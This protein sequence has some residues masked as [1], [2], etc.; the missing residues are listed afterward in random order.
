M[1][2]RRITF[3]CELLEDLHAGSGLGWLGQIDDCHARDAQ[4]RAVVWSSTLSGVLRDVADELLA[5]E[6]PLATSARVRRLFGSEGEDAR[7]SLITRSLHFEFPDQPGELVPFHV[8]TS[9]A[10]EVHSRRPLDHTLRTIEMASAGQTAQAELRFHGDDDDDRFL[11]L[12]LSRLTAI[13]GGK[14]RGQGQIRI[15]LI[16]GETGD[17]PAPPTPTLPTKGER[18]LRVLLR[19]LEPVCI[20]TTGFPGNVIATESFLPGTALRGAWLTAMNQCGATSVDEF[21]KSANVNFGNGTFVDTNFVGASLFSVISWPLPLTAQAAKATERSS[22]T[23]NGDWWKQPSWWAT[24]TE[25]HSA[26]LAN[27]SVE[28]DQLHPS[29]RQRA[30]QSNHEADVE[31]VKFKRVKSEDVLVSNDSGQTLFR[32]RPDCRVLLRNRSPVRRLGRATDSRRDQATKLDQEKG[33]LFA[34]TVLSEGQHFVA[35][36]TFGSTEL[37]TQFIEQVKSLLATPGLTGRASEASA[38]WLRVGRGGRPV[39]VERYEWLSEDQPTT[40]DGNATEFTLTLTSDLIGRRDD[41]TFLTTLDAAALESLTGA[42]GLIG[43]IEV[44]QRV[45]VSETRIVRGFNTAAGT[46]RSPALA[47]KRGS[48]F[49]VRSS[50]TGSDGIKLRDLFESLAKTYA[51]SGGLGE[52]TEEGFGRFFLNSPAHRSPT[53][54][55]TRTAPPEPSVTSAREMAIDAVLSA[56]REMNLDRAVGLKGFPAR[57]QWQWLRHEAEVPSKQPKAIVDEIVTAAKKL[58]GAN[59]K[60]EVPNPDP[61]LVEN[62]HKKKN[63]SL[64]QCLRFYIDKF[65]HPNGPDAKSQR[66]FLIYL[67]RWVVVQLDHHRRSDNSGNAQPESERN[68]VAT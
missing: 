58:S 16:A 59:W 27:L 39:L 43:N 30:V 51:A 29:V 47:I 11:K 31:T 34:T 52:R 23:N 21:A 22:V 65:K 15:T 38:A 14:T 32:A 42:K 28:R 40:L 6:H 12:C 54:A 55:T 49:L 53:V 9:T 19:L 7:S 33:D 35:D 4:G 10:R 66:I 20:P 3:T 37:A 46:F 41:L 1:N 57:S 56:V 64:V 5:L 62:G 61:N 36:I 45:S 67:C 50:G 2:E 18:R 25:Q 63:A 48:A 44:D 68:E 24:R 60:H 13:G 26:W 8:V 17:C